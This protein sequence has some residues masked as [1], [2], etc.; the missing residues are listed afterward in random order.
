VQK[1]R[2]E[3]FSD[4]GR[5][6][7]K[8]WKLVGEK[9]GVTEGPIHMAN[10]VQWVNVQ[11]KTRWAW[12]QE[13]ARIFLIHWL[14]GPCESKDRFQHHLHRSSHTH[15]CA[16]TD[17]DTETHLHAHTHKHTLAHTRKQTRTHARTH[18][19]THLQNDTSSLHQRDVLS[20]EGVVYFTLQI[21]QSESWCRGVVSRCLRV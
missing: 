3:N 11:E 10:H 9:I 18:T 6:R 1:N 7:S 8:S 16:H 14:R 19:R 4:I 5:S 2:Q 12:R 15:S 20:A 17:T 21:T 13:R